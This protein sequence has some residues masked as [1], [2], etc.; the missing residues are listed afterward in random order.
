VTFFANYT[1][2][3]AMGDTDGLT[4]AANSYD[5]STEYGRSSF[6]VRHAFSAGGTFDAPLGLRF[7]P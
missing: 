6:D 5:L 3:K 2:N 7:S 4:F 1:L